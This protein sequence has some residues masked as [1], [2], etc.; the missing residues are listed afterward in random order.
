MENKT[1]QL[2]SAK[3]D[4]DL[5]QTKQVTILR[6]Q[7]NHPV[8]ELTS[9]TN[10]SKQDGI[11]LGV[12][13]GG[14]EH[15]QA[16]GTYLV[17]GNSTDGGINFSGG[18]RYDPA[19]KSGASGFTWFDV[20]HLTSNGKQVQPDGAKFP[21]FLTDASWNDGWEHGDSLPDIRIGYSDSNK[22]VAGVTFGWNSLR[23]YANID[24]SAV[25]NFSVDGANGTFKVGWIT[26]S[27]WPNKII[28]IYN[29]NESSHGGIAFPPDGNVI[30]FGV[31][32]RWDIKGK[33]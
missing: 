23:P 17:I 21:L 14:T 16:N 30:L 33:G 20:L 4:T 3:A 18:M 29:S 27:D 5:I 28:C 9:T 24:L 8:A 15:P 2:P 19:G 25:T 12:V 11:T 31:G 6:G 13:S 26:W 32:K 1:S 10:Q 22:S 7:D